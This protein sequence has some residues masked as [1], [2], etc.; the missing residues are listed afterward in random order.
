MAKEKS[1]FEKFQEINAVDE[2]QRLTAQAADTAAEQL[3]IVERE[4]GPIDRAIFNRCVDAGHH[5]HWVVRQL[6]QGIESEPDSRWVPL[7]QILAFKI[8]GKNPSKES[9][10]E[11][12]KTAVAAMSAYMNVALEQWAIQ[13]AEHRDKASKGFSG[14]GPNLGSIWKKLCEA[15]FD[16][17]GLTGNR[18]GGE[19]DYYSNLTDDLF[20]RK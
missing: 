12:V 8:A 17:L 4:L 18:S 6:W 19:T 3:A 10:A 5:P 11:A 7:L 13:S 20:N 15:G 2:S 9:F 16:R 1:L 14:K